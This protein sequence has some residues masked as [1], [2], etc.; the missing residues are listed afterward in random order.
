MSTRKGALNSQRAIRSGISITLFGSGHKSIEFF[1]AFQKIVFQGVERACRCGGTAD[2]D[3]IQAR[4]RLTRQDRVDTGAQAAT[5]AVTDDGIAN[6][7]AGRK[8]DANQIVS[9]F[10][11]RSFADLHHHPRGCPLALCPGDSKK[12]TPLSQAYMTWLCVRLGHAD[13]VTTACP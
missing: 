6:L 1:Q 3:N 4:L 9:G 8:A 12:L 5:D 11:G 7:A 10:T 13:A 2:Y